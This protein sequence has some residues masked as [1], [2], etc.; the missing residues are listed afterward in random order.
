MDFLPHKR[1]YSPIV[2]ELIMQ[3]IESVSIFS[4]DFSSFFHFLFDTS[5]HL[6]RIRNP[7]S[8][9]I[10]SH[11]LLPPFKMGTKK[12]HSIECSSFHRYFI[13]S[14]ALPDRLAVPLL[15]WQAF[16]VSNYFCRICHMYS[17]YFF[18]PHPIQKNPSLTVSVQAG[19]ST[20]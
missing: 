12:E 11:H 2:I 8:V 15:S 1:I 20:T 10:S 6:G 9:S 5:Y 7:D 16:S 14:T 17:C 3:L 18:A 4:C 13:P 19:V